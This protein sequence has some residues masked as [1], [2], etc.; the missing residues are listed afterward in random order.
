MANI[1]LTLIIFISI[2][3]YE[4][5]KICNKR[6]PHKIK[7]Y[8]NIVFTLFFMRY[9]ILNIMFLV[10]GIKYLYL[11]IPLIF[12]NYFCVITSAIVIIYILQRNDKK[13]FTYALFLLLLFLL[14]YILLVFK[15]KAIIGIDKLYGYI[16]Y[17]NNYKIINYVYFI[18]ISIIMVYSIVKYEKFKD[19]ISF[20]ILIGTELVSLIE[21]GLFIV[22]IKIFPQLILTDLC[23]ILSLN[24]ILNKFKR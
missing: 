23:W 4:G 16:T 24:Y 1:Y 17:L 11:V 10:N 7:I 21:I 12:T 2:M 22:N 3:I 13:K 6:A 15:F 9:C 14:A 19:K 18:I 5:I 8:C 20:N